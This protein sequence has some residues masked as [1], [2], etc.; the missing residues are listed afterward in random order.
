MEGSVVEK[1]INIQCTAIF[2]ENHDRGEK[3]LFWSNCRVMKEWREAKISRVILFTLKETAL[4]SVIL[5]STTTSRIY[6]IVMLLSTAATVSAVLLTTDQQRQEQ[7]EAAICAKTDLSPASENQL[8]GC[9]SYYRLLLQKVTDELARISHR[10]RFSPVSA[11]LP[12]RESAFLLKRLNAIRMAHEEQIL[13][14]SN[15]GA[16]NEEMHQKRRRPFVPRKNNTIEECRQLSQQELV[17]ELKQKGTYNPDLMAWDASGIIRFLDRSIGDQYER[18][19]KIR[20]SAEETTER[21]VEA[22]ERILSELNVKCDLRSPSV[23]SRLQNLTSIE[24]R[25][26][27]ISPSIRTMDSELV[28]NK[29][30]TAERVIDSLIASGAVDP[31]SKTHSTIRKRQKLIGDVHVIPFGCDKRGGEEDGYLRLCGACQAI[32]RLPDTFF[33]P[34][35]NEVMCDNDKACLYFYDFPHGKC[36]QKHMNFVVLRN[37]GTDDC[38]IWQKF[39]L[40]VRVSC[41]CFVDEMSFFAKYSHIMLE[42]VQNFKL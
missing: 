28:R 26:T 12:N 25:R 37:V 41:E 38:Q 22:L 10:K 29:R 31:F 2:G 21:N 27:I 20:P 24:S 35:I 11:S 18:Q 42:I 40:N 36:K 33:P 39:N 14:R 7:D 15:S 30:E 3:V 17:V 13:N 16:S 4:W 9:I 19:S 5:T 1:S 23:I 8:L 32:R 34:F 6:F